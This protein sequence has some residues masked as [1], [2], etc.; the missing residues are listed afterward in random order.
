MESIAQRML[1]RPVRRVV[2][3]MEMRV[4]KALEILR[5]L[6]SGREARTLRPNALRI[7]IYLSRIWHQA[8]RE[9][10]SRSIVLFGGRASRGGVAASRSNVMWPHILH[11]R[12]RA[13]YLGGCGLPLALR[14][15]LFL[16]AFSFAG[17]IVGNHLSRIF[18]RERN[19]A[20]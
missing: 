18:R 13:S 1:R 3:S 19:S 15:H 5:A 7:E 12:R 14:T 20:Q 6:A 9:I 4:N 11:Q 17:I 8:A 10:M 2:A 16:S